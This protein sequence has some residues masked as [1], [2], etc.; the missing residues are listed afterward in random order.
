M[1]S[2]IAPLF[3]RLYDTTGINLVFFYEQ[4]EY[5]RLLHGMLVT[6]ELAVGCLAVSL[7]IGVVGAWAQGAD[8]R[9]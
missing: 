7:A 1:L 9:S 4:Y 3:K 8:P 2:L 6:L 5:E